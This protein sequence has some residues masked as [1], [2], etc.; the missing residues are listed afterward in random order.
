MT[1]TAPA[2]TVCS[3]AILPVMRD[4]WLRN[5]VGDGNRVGVYSVGH[6]STRG[7]RN[8]SSR[9]RVSDSRRIGVDGVVD[10]R[11]SDGDEEVVASWRYRWRQ[12]ASSPAAKSKLA[13]FPLL[14]TVVL[15]APARRGLDEH[16]GGPG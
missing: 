12:L 3:T 9:H 5:C 2:F 14:A 10:G 8:G 16:L 6:Q 1:V 13:L 11:F 4:P 7:M 15:S